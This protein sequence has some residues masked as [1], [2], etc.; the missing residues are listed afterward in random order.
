MDQILHNEQLAIGR[1]ERPLA[2]QQQINQNLFKLYHKM[3]TT[4]AMV[5]II[6]AQ[7]EHQLA[8]FDQI[9]RHLNLNKIHI[10]DNSGYNTQFARSSNIISAAARNNPAMSDYAVT[11]MR[12]QVILN[13]H[14][15]VIVAL[16][17]AT[18]YMPSP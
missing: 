13:T 11:A 7:I 17:P 3:P 10:G 18:P 2:Q 1:N 15:Q 16:P 14:L 6:N 4:A 8:L 12:R 5:S 9:Q